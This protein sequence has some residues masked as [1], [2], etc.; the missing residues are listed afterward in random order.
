V[1]LIF[2]LKALKPE[3]YRERAAI[4]HTGRDGKDLIPILENYQNE[5]AVGQAIRDSGVDRADIFLTIP[6]LSGIEVEEAFLTT[7]HL[8][9]NFQ[10]KAG[11]F[12]ERDRMFK[13][14]RGTNNGSFDF[15]RD[16]NNP[17]DTNYAYSTALLGY[18]RTYTESTSRPILAEEMKVASQ[19]LDI[20]RPACRYCSSSFPWLPLAL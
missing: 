9:G 15:S 17:F 18:F 7:T 19:P 6:N 2:R 5:D 14:F 16:V 10:I 20:V 11:I 12:L 13:G 1:L 4:E 8:P 3:M